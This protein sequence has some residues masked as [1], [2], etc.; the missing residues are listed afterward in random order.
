MTNN[1]AILGAQVQGASSSSAHDDKRHGS[2]I[3]HPLA[4]SPFEHN[5]GDF[6]DSGPFT[7]TVCQG[8]P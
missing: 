3:L 1:L 2:H 8:Q 4:L 5:F 7:A 6:K